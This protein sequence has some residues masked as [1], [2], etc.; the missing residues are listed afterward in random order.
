MVIVTDYDIGT[1]VRPVDNDT[2][3][4]VE[5]IEIKVH[6]EDDERIEYHVKFENGKTETYFEFD[7]EGEE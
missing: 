2:I 3:G 6:S 1:R 7:L 4:V 5:R